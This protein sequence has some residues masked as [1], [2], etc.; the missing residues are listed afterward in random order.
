[1]LQSN[2]RGAMVVEQNSG[3][4]GDG[5]MARNRSHRNRQIQMPR[6]TDRDEPI[7]RTMLKQLHILLDQV[8]PEV[9]T[10]DQI[11]ISRLHEVIFNSSQNRNVVALTYLG[12]HDAD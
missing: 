12:N 6:S 4:A 2:F 11:K 1:M 10:G 5:M 3:N 7:D 8:R 9:M